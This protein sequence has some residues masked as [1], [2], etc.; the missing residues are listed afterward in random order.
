[1]SDESHP[2]L[3]PA[4]SRPAFEP[5][6]PHAGVDLSD[7]E[8]EVAQSRL[9]ALVNEEFDARERQAADAAVDDEDDADPAD[10]DAD[11]KDDGA[12]TDADKQ[13]RRRSRG[14]R[15]R[16]QIAELRR[17]N[18]RLRGHAGNGHD[19]QP[20]HHDAPAQLSADDLMRMTPEQLLAHADRVLQAD[21]EETR[22][23]EV[24][25]EHERKE[26]ISE[27]RERGADPLE[28]RKNSVAY[29]KAMDK[30]YELDLR[31][32]SAIAGLVKDHPRVGPLCE[33]LANR[34]R[35]LME[36][37]K[38]ASQNPAKAGAMLG[39]LAERVMKYSEAK[40]VSNAPPPRR[41]PQGGAAPRSEAAELD[42]WLSKTYPRR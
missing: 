12:D 6:R 3:E 13:P 9:D 42:A 25:R 23:A 40:M 4:P 30:A 7:L 34:P 26:R 41:A 20:L 16:D 11:E 5:P 38:A 18:E 22:Q 2:N 14:D 15:Y 29:A 31:V 36:I 17:E 32:H 28:R 24:L 39:A 8:A 19:T 35:E 21:A 33:Y 37:N 10:D 27:W 1:M